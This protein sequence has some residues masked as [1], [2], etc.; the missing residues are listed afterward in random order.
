MNCQEILYLLSGLKSGE[1]SWANYEFAI[2]L[3]KTQSSMSGYLHCITKK[4][5]LSEALRISTLQE[6]SSENRLLDQ[7]GLF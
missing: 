7:D 4:T 2:F 3:S 5:N 6:N 1:K